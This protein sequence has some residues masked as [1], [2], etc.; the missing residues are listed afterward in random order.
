MGSMAARSSDPHGGPSSGGRLGRVLLR[1][2]LW[3]GAVV[4]AGRIATFAM[5]A[6]L[7]RFLDKEGFGTLG[8]ARSMVMLAGVLALQGMPTVLVRFVA[9]FSATGE[10]GKARSA[11]NRAVA[12][13]WVGAC[14]GG[15]AV[16]WALHGGWGLHEESRVRLEPSWGAVALW[17]LGHPLAELCIG[18]LRG[19]KLFATSAAL[20]HLALPLAVMVGVLLGWMSPLTRGGERL[21][22]VLWAFVFATLLR[23]GVAGALLAPWWRRLPPGDAVPWRTLLGTGWSLGAQ[24][25]LFTVSTQGLVWWTSRAAGDAD[26]A[27]LVAATQLASFV[28]FPLLIFSNV[29]DPLIAQLHA[30]GER[31]RMERVVRAA[32][33]VT[34]ASGGLVALILGVGAP[35]V[36]KWAYGAAYVQDAP[37]LR[38]LVGGELLRVVLGFGGSVLAMTAGHIVRLRNGVV[39]TVLAGGLAAWWVPAWG[40]EGSAWVRFVFLGTMLAANWAVARA[41]AGVWVH[42]WWRLGEVVALWRRVRDKGGARRGG[43]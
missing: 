41:H 37:V 24:T 30:Q 43:A 35:V 21:S 28:S 4:V 39:A 33:T 11:V 15:G 7:A 18:G 31:E 9:S 29:V 23:L 2:T 17:V 25:W 8:L 27:R 42:P 20:R 10:H 40:A 1:G 14:L 26:V 32:A 34:A 3:T 38:V 13:V 5:Y 6:A 36:L 16:A 22:W 12:A 19:R